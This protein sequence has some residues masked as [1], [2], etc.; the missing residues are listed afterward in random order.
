[1]T[2][3]A[4][5]TSVLSPAATSLRATP[6]EPSESSGDNTDADS[7]GRPLEE[8]RVSAV[9]AWQT[10]R[11]NP[12]VAVPLLVPA[13]VLIKAIRVASAHPDTVIGLLAA[14]DKA[15]ITA[16][17]FVHLLYTVAIITVIAT[18]RLVLR[19]N[20][21]SRGGLDRATLGLTGSLAV[22]LLFLPWPVVAAL[23]LVACLAC[24]GH[25]L[26]DRL[27]LPGARYGRAA[28]VGRLFYA[29]ILALYCPSA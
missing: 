15:T 13:F 11:E 25:V 29:V 23:P 12:I 5:G 26:L 10:L 21:P 22:T 7:P 6:A 14:A 3:T 16:G 4:R 8:M 2:A 27:P 20:Q 24:L 9:A 28:Q 18:A 19:R 1:M 17:G